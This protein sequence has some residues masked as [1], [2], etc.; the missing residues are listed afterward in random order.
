[1]AE[2]YERTIINQAVREATGG[3]GSRITA[4]QAGGGGSLSPD[5]SATSIQDPVTGAR[6]FTPGLSIPGGPDL[7][8][9]TE[10]EV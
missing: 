3:M 10:S 1:M 4:R 6:W 9:P 2:S 8:R 5:L 7:I